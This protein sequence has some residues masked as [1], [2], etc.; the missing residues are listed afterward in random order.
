MGGTGVHDVKLTK[1]QYKVG[2]KKRFM[3][4]FSKLCQFRRQSEVG[5]LVATIKLT[6]ACTL[7]QL[8]ET[9][10]CFNWEGKT[11]PCSLGISP[12][13]DTFCPAPA[14]RHGNRFPGLLVCTLSVLTSLPRVTPL[15]RTPY[16][17]APVSLC[18]CFI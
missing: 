1:N 6:D 16:S 10:D 5:H 2:E 14:N 4:I 12:L 11:W 13:R 18:F 7:L 3:P 15:S 8:A 17:H 9:G